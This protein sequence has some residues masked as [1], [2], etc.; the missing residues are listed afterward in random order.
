[1]RKNIAKKLCACMLAAV[2]FSMV[3]LLSACD[4]AGESSLNSSTVDNEVKTATI[5]VA[6]AE[7]KILQSYEGSSKLQAIGQ[8]YDSYMMDEFSLSAVRNEYES[9]QIVITPTKNVSSFDVSVSDFKCGNDVLAKDNFEIGYEYYHEV[10][11][12]FGAKNPMEPGMY[13]DAVLPMATAKAYGLNKIAANNNQ[14][15]LITVKVPKTQAAGVYNGT[16]TV[17]LDGEK[18]EKS[19]TIEVV[20]YTLSDTVTVK[21]CMPFNASYLMFL[22]G[23]ET[24]ERYE[25]LCGQ[26]NKF[27][28]A[29]NYVYG[30]TVGTGSAETLKQI[31]ED[32]VEVMLKAAQDPAVPCYGIRT[33]GLTVNTSSLPANVREKLTKSTAVVLKEENLKIYMQTFIDKSIETGV[34]LLKKAYV[35]MG[36]IID[37]PEGNN[38]QA[39]VDYVCQQFNNVLAEMAEYARAQG[40]SEELIESILGVNNVVTTWNSGNYELVDT[41]C[42]EPQYYDSTATL[43]KYYEHRANGGDYWWYTCLNPD[44]PYPTIRIDDN[45]V[46]AR[47]MYWMMKEYDISGYLTWELIDPSDN[48]P[49]YGT[50]L[51]GIEQYEDVMRNNADVGDGYYFYPGKIFGLEESV[52]AIRLYYMRDGGEDYDAIYDLENRLYPSLANAYGAKISVDGVLNEVY[53]SLYSLNQAYCSSV[54]LGNAKSTLN[55]LLAWAEDGIAISDYQLSSNGKI[56]A[57]VYAPSGVEVK[58]NGKKLTGGPSSKGIVY[59]VNV[60]AGKFNLTIDGRTLTLG[61]D[62]EEISKP[63]ASRFTFEDEDQNV[64]DSIQV[65]AN[66]YGGSVDTMQVKATA[67]VGA[68]LYSLDSGCLTA[69][70]NSLLIYCYLDSVANIKTT[71]EVYNGKITRSLDTVNLKPGYNVLRF[72][73]IGDLDW[74]SLNS[75]KSLVFTFTKPDGVTE[76]TLDIEK[77]AILK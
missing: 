23:E 7:D 48:F 40:G 21:S 31:A 34:D 49:G 68:M 22:E 45:G 54:E 44:P 43:E 46:S 24:Q 60:D 32:E 74:K 36:S 42:P 71:V 28:L 30:M 66:K 26:L 39:L 52:P 73:R 62:F 75:V 53:G 1:M 58:L 77:L 76:F 8:L 70:A 37:E 57:K 4:N 11:G 17:D 2:S 41:Y 18:V 9:R 67:E 25:I 50:N 16:I 13:P 3:G 14:A 15:I 47:T 56:S 69:N 65:I 38:T 63:T 29:A 27:R 51:H 19:A 55:T 59:S 12:V 20:D 64:L 61:S 33:N 10:T 6:Y 35:Y 5:R 72:D